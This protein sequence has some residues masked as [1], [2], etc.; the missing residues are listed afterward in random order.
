M[1]NDTEKCTGY[2]K[3]TNNDGSKSNIDFGYNNRD[4]W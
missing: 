4:G 3:A 2:I 1:I